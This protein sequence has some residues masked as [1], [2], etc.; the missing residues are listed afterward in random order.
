MVNCL[1]L[2]IR[3]ACPQPLPSSVRSACPQPLPSFV[4]SARMM[5]GEAHRSYPSTGWAVFS[6]FEWRCRD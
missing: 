4:R 3:S 1:P 5:T 2:P 6:F